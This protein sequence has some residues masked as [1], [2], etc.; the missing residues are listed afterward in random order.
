MVLRI[1]ST[2]PGPMFDESAVDCTNPF[3]YLGKIAHGHVAL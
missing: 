2:P 1:D 3:T